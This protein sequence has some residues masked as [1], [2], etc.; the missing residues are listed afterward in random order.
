MDIPKRA[1]FDKAELMAMEKETTGIYLS[2]HP[3]DDYRK[4]LKNTHVIPI[5]EL[6]DEENHYEDNQM[7][8]V[9][10]IVQTVKTK[11]TGTIPSWPM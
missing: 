7:V 9:A 1:E 11:S 10:G 3:M 4:L 5:G 2:G 6:M 8:S